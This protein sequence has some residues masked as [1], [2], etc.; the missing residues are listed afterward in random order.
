[1]FGKLDI[2]FIVLLEIPK[3]Q[4]MK[5]IVGGREKVDTNQL[6]LKKNHNLVKLQKVWKIAISDW[7]SICVFFSISV[8]LP[9]FEF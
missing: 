2:K 5:T 8:T 9:T 7:Y 3:C 1:M 4:G 6:K